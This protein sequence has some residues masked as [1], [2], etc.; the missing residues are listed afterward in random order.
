M[1]CNR[2]GSQAVVVAYIIVLGAWF[3][4]FNAGLVGAVLL[5]LLQQM[6]WVCCFHFSFTSLC[7]FCT[8]GLVLGLVELVGLGLASAAAVAA[9]TAAV[10]VHTPLYTH[11]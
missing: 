11:L 2:G 9:A 10:V 7:L 1:K 4:K 6:R 5:L 3:Y 8:L